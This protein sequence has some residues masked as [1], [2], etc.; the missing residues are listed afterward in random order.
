MSRIVRQSHLWIGIL[1]VGTVITNF[2]AMAFDEPPAVVT[3][4][5]LFPL[6][7]MMF[8]G[9]YLFALP[10]LGKRASKGSVE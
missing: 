1:F 10:Y 8:S 4:A 6:A 9:L 2:V 5:P 7:L 3:Y